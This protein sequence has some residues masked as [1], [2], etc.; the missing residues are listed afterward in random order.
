[1]SN[2]NRQKEFKKNHRNIA[3][4][5]ETGDRDNITLGL[6]LNRDIFD[7]CYRYLLNLSYPLDFNKKLQAVW[8]KYE[9]Y[10]DP[11]L[12]INFGSFFILF[13]IEDGNLFITLFDTDFKYSI[14]DLYGTSWTFGEI[15]GF[16]KTVL[17][18]DFKN[19]YKK[20]LF[21]YTEP[22]LF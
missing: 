15:D 4:L 21:P 1:M 12:V 20:I 5:L 6:L 7:S 8:D 18:N 19:E 14:S 3:L 22:T 11:Q 10:G 16:I 13:D 17:L 9:F 2:I